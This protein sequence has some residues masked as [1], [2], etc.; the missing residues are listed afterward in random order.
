APARA[1]DHPGVPNQHGPVTPPF[2]QCPPVGEDT[3]CASLITINAN[4]T[5]TVDVDPMQP[6][7]D[8][9]EDQLIGLKNNFQ[10]AICS[11]TLSSDAN[12]FGLD[13][14]GLCANSINPHPNG[15]PFGDTGYEGPGTSFEIV[16]FQN[17]TVKFS[18]CVAPGQSAYFSLEESALGQISFT[19]ISTGTHPAPAVRPA[20]LL[21]LGIALTAAGAFLVSRRRGKTSQS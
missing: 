3:G 10:A 11:I 6:A 17:G 7:Y 18:P 13:G 5:A 12:I 20:M 15:C 16:D 8:G 21:A 19:N 4:G 14:D 2:T 9:S 1:E